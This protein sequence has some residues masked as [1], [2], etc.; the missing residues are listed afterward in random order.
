MSTTG[1][2]NSTSSKS[3]GKLTASAATFRASSEG[4]AGRS[5]P[6]SVT[7]QTAPCRGCTLIAQPTALAALR[8]EPAPLR[9]RRDAVVHNH[10]GHRGDRRPRRPCAEHSDARSNHLPCHS[11]AAPALPSDPVWPSRFVLTKSSTWSSAAR[12][13]PTWAFRGG[14]QSAPSASSSAMAS[15]PAPRRRRAGAATACSP[16]RRVLVLEATRR[17]VG[18]PA[19]SAV[20]SGRIRQGLGRGLWV[21]GGSAG[22]SPQKKKRTQQATGRQPVVVRC[23]RAPA[24]ARPIRTVQPV[25]R[26]DDDRRKAA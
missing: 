16:R 1:T 24:S 14:K 2:E 13:M 23:G 11:G 12:V 21:G 18:S 22:K 26:R 3:S 7:Q 20:G 17:A 10:L 5:R 9:A 6:A 25:A 19:G 8:E 15:S 4:R